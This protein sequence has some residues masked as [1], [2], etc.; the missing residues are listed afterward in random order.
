MIAATALALAAAIAAS[1]GTVQVAIVRQADSAALR[2]EGTVMIAQPGAKSKP[3]EWKGELTLRP[4]EG[5]LR[6]ADMRLKTETRLIPAAGARIRVGGN[7]YRGALIL[8]LDIGQTL[9]IV[10]EASVEEYLEGVLPP[11]RWTPS[12]PSRR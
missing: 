9:T 6:L 7:Y 10:E 4:R 2:P 5:G 11:T 1:A 8:R 12:G 3:L